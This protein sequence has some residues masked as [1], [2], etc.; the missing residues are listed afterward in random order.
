M[1]RSLFIGCILATLAL[2]ANSAHHESSPRKSPA[3]S[4]SADCTDVAFDMLDCITYLSDG[5]EAAKPTASCCAGFEAVLSLDAEC[6]CFALK[7]S[8]DFGVALNLT[9]AAAL[10]SKCGVSAPPLSKCGISV[11]ATGAPEPAPPT[12][13]PP[14]PVIEPATNNQ[15]SA[16]APAPSNSD[17]NGVSAAAPVIIEVPAQAPAKGMAYSISAPFSVL[18]S[19]AVA[20]TPLFLWV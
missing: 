6:L 20:S 13:S 15:P 5:S 2:L 10:S 7:H 12:E 17:D 19:C 4:P 3:P 9:R 16:P 11:P 14:Y 1:K 18:I 8:A